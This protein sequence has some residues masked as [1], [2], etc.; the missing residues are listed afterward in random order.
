MRHL[1]R[2]EGGREGGSV[3]SAGQNNLE[4]PV[5]LESQDT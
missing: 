2:C 5:K 3:S 4:G 1:V